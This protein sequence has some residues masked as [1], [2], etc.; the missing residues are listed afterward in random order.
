MPN[1]SLVPLWEKVAD[2]ELARGRSD[3]GFARRDL[4]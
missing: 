2:P 4:S 1:S 3:E